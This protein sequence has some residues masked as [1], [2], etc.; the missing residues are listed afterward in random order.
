MKQLFAT[1]MLGVFII[2][3]YAAFAF[4][5]LDNAYYDVTVEGGER[6]CASVL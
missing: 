1:F 5:Y 4:V 2:Y 3:I 6:T